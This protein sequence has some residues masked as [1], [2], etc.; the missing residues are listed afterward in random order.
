MILYVEKLG[1]RRKKFS[2]AICT[3]NT[4]EICK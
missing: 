4:L 3:F 2:H 1:V